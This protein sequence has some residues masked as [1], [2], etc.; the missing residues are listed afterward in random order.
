MWADTWIAGYLR[1]ALQLRS[2]RR[3]NAELERR[4][5]EQARRADRLESALVDSEVN[6]CEQQL[7][8][9]TLAEVVRSMRSHPSR[10]GES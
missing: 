10:G 5:V 3:R 9:D 6:Y 4:L 1:I 7:R 2:L 8:A